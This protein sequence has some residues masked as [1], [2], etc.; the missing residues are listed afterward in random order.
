MQPGQAFS[1]S[2]NEQTF[3]VRT[4]ETGAFIVCPVNSEQPLRL[5]SRHHYPGITHLQ[6]KQPHSIDLL[7]RVQM[8]GEIL[9]AVGLSIKHVA[10]LKQLQLMQ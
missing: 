7:L 9:F 6:T 10:L 4:G 1:L 5:C 8:T 3:V 2:A